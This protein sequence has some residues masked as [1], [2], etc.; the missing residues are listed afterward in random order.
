MNH[1]GG[2]GLAAGSPLGPAAAMTSQSLHASQ[3]LSFDVAVIGGSTTGVFAAVRAA[4]KGMK[5]ALVENNAL[6]GGTATA[7]FVPVWHSMQS[8]D[9]SKTVIG[10]LTKTILD[11]LGARGEAITH[12][13][14]KTPVWR[15]SSLNV[16][17][18]SIALDELVMEYQSQA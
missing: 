8:L 11:R 2:V 5:V 10:G 12:N 6:F 17:A 1:Q 13:E 14:N 3:P 16:A 15:T 18:L 7:G 9:G 4:E